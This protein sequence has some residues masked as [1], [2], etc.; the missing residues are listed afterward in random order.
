MKKI[1]TRLNR[2]GCEDEA[3]TATEYAVM[4]VMILLVAF[5]TIIVLGQ[6]VDQAFNRFVELFN[7]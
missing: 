5:G 6:Q 1:L 2:L 3:A 4:L 7:P